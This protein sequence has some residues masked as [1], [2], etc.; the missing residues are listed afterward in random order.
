MQETSSLPSTTCGG[1]LLY[2]LVEFT[3][4]SVV[5]SLRGRI[6]FFADKFHFISLSISCH[7]AC[8]VPLICLQRGSEEIFARTLHP[9]LA[10]VIQA[11][12]AVPVC[13]CIV[14]ENL[15][16]TQPFETCLMLTYSACP[17]GHLIT[18]IPSAPL[19]SARLI[20]SRSS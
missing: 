16:G 13:F 2:L 9:R 3:K 7:G 6:C 12:I 15:F 20:R 5:G 14:G 1:V 8:S 18:Y 17:C 11:L 10:E 4:N 19:S